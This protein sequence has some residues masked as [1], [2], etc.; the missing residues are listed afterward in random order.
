MTKQ[1]NYVATVTDANSEFPPKGQPVTNSDR[2]IVSAR[3]GQN[4]GSVGAKDSWY[5]RTDVEPIASYPNNRLPR[6]Q[7]LIPLDCDFTFGA[8]EVPSTPIPPVLDSGTALTLFFDSSGSMDQVLPVLLTMADTVLRPC[9]LPFYNNNN[10]LYDQRVTVVPISN[11][12]GIRWLGTPI[13]AGASKVVN[14]TFANEFF[15]R[16]TTEYTPG[17]VNLNSNPWNFINTAEPTVDYINDINYTNANLFANVRGISFRVTVPSSLTNGTSYN[18]VT[19]QFYNAVYQGQ[20][21]YSGA[22]GL[23]GNP[24]ARLVDNVSESGSPTYYA[25]KVI[26]GMKLL[27]YDINYC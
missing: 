19:R 7:D 21:R 2:G 8:V 9:L 22:M 15:S 26:E 11:E 14:M 3:S 27:G 24:F 23:S 17:N 5:I 10:T 1:T 4:S 12:A 20:G 6:W 18:N 25:N 16:Y 13:P